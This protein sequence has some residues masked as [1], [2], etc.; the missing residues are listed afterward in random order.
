L[1]VFPS[2]GNRESRRRCR[3]AD[4]PGANSLCLPQGAFIPTRRPS[5]RGLSKRCDSTRKNLLR[6]NQKR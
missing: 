1:V 2:P 5:T 3:Q 4:P 6:E